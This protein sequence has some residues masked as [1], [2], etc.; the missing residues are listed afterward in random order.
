[1]GLDGSLAADQATR[2]VR[3]VGI[4]LE[5]PTA[6]PVNGTTLGGFAI[7]ASLPMTTGIVVVA[8]RPQFEPATRTW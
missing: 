7:G 1:M 3:V 8:L 2:I 4:E 5:T 6:W